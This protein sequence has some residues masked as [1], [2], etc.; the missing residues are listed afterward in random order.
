MGK[1]L[2]YE[3]WFKDGLFRG[4]PQVDKHGIEEENNIMTFTFGDSDPK[5][6]ARINLD[7]VNF[8]EIMEE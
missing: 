6:K 2:R 8:I 5:H 7:N 4:F 1:T 3:V